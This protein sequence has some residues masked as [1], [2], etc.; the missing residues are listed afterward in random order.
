MCHGNSPATRLLG[1]HAIMLGRSGAAHF[2]IADFDTLPMGNLKQQAGAFLSDLGNLKSEV[3][4]ALFA[5]S[6]PR[7][8]FAS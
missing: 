6:I 5:T 8:T 4:R 1:V 2:H 7:P 3:M